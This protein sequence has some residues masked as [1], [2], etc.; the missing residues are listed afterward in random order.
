MRH[1]RTNKYCFFCGSR[2]Q[3]QPTL[4]NPKAPNQH[5]ILTYACPNCSD[6]L[7]KPVLLSIIKKYDDAIPFD[8]FQIKTNGASKK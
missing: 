8:S 3:Y 6:R 4:S 2:L 1:K 5:R 7:N